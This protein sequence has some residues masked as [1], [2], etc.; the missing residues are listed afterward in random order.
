MGFDYAGRVAIVTGASSGIGRS[1]AL[2]LASRGTNVVA[3][4][5]RKALLDE[6][7]E[8]CRAGAPESRAVAADV[9][10]RG[11]VE[12]L[13]G[14]ALSGLGKVDVLVNNAGIPMRKHA[15]RL[16][17]EDVERVMAVNFLGTVYATLAVLPSMLERREGRIVNI[18]SIA[19]RI[20]SPRES[21]YSAS[22]FAMVGFS[23]GLAADL[24]GTGVRMHVVN[25][26]PIR[27]EIWEKLDEPPSYHGK[28]Y[29]PE[30]VSAA[31]LACLE[32]GGF[33]RWVPKRL[34]IVPVFRAVVPDQFIKGVARYDRRHQPPPG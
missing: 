30:Q 9:T 2:D 7:V 31:V 20:G 13:V 29:P 32:R 15:T 1:I 24:A 17:V 26:G 22:K 19:G 34:G 18:A 25:P 3:V 33:E 5:R 14:D 10:D 28:F 16:T 27:T 4:A 21:A 11:A 23:E 8:R 12:A 6:V